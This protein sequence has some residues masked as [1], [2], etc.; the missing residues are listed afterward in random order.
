MQTTPTLYIVPTIDVKAKVKDH[1]V[2]ADLQ[3]ADL[4]AMSMRFK[5]YAAPRERHTATKML[6]EKV[7]QLALENLK[8]KTYYG[9]LNS[10]YCV[11]YLEVVGTLDEITKV[12]D[13]MIA[14]TTPW[15]GQL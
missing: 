3:M 13:A 2:H 10:K 5:M 7:D 14:I 11:I 1:P 15:S 4:T 12:R 8:S 6:Q 9:M